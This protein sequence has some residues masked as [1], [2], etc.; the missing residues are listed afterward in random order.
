[1]LSKKTIDFSSLNFSVCKPEIP[2]VSRFPSFKIDNK[3]ISCSK[4][5]SQKRSES[6]GA[7]AVNIRPFFGGEMPIPVKKGGHLEKRIIGNCLFIL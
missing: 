1:M 7:A 2:C 5:R 6:L 4:T 3:N